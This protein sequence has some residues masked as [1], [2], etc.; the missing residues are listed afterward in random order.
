MAE[1]S[2]NMN[3][4]TVNDESDESFMKLALAEARK[5]LDKDEVPVGCVI[6]LDSSVIGRA[7]NQ[8]ETLRDP[9]AHAEMIAITQAAEAME[10]WR[11]EGTTMYVT[12]EPCVMCAGAIVLA[13]IRR[14]VYGAADPKA[15][16]FGSV[17][18][19]PGSGKLNHKPEARGG[20]LAEECGLLLKDFFSRMR[21]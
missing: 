3:S 18:D 21:K 10:A 4:M 12:L 19:I 16:A 2:K 1:E 17:F 15:G 8:R 6:V 14:V 9:T 11:L 20:V 7:F 5:A 13:R